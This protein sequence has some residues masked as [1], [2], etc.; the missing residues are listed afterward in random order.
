[1]EKTGSD[2]AGFSLD[3]K[4]RENV[5]LVVGWGFWG[6]EIASTFSRNVIE[7][8][9]YAPRGI[10][11]SMDMSRLKPMGDDGQKAFAQVMASLNDF[12]LGQVSVIT[13]SH[14]TKLQL[15]RIARESG[16]KDKVRF[17]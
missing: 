10:Q 14:L 17:G 3:L 1:M 2:E 13:T 16:P 5:M 7:A 12:R 6:E 11:L 9:R 8:C 4:A 15:M